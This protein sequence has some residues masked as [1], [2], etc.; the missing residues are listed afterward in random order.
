MLLCECP[1]LRFL[2]GSYALV[3]EPVVPARRV[4][5]SVWVLCSGVRSTMT[6]IVII[7][8]DMQIIIIGVSII[9]IGISIIITILS[10]IR[11]Q[12]LF[13]LLCCGNCGSL[14]WGGGIK[15]S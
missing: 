5:C 10:L 1:K 15:L 12:G 13:D 7:S 14:S 8:M 9:I 11:F 3:S 6:S 2:F 4:L